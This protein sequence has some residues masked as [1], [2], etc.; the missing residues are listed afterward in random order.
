MQTFEGRNNENDFEKLPTAI[1]CQMILATDEGPGDRVDERASTVAECIDRSKVKSDD[2][3][4]LGDGSS[5]VEHIQL[6]QTNYVDFKNVM[7]KSSHVGS[8]SADR[9][10]SDVRESFS[11]CN[12]IEEHIAESLPAP[13]DDKVFITKHVVPAERDEMSCTSTDIHVDTRPYPIHV[14]ERAVSVP[15]NS[16]SNAVDD[17]SLLR[18]S[19]IEL[20]EEGEMYPQ[21]QVV[22]RQKTGQDAAK[23][24]KADLSS[25]M[26]LSAIASNA[27]QQKHPSSSGHLQSRKTTP[28]PPPPMPFHAPSPPAARQASAG[29]PPHR[30]PAKRSASKRIEVPA[31]T[32]PPNCEV[33]AKR[34]RQT[35]CAEHGA[36]CGGMPGDACAA[37]FVAPFP[38]VAAPP[39][40]LRAPVAV[41]KRDA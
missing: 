24:C 28:P 20:H 9:S 3:P 13:T 30:S 37:G 12:Q 38:V 5:S 7:V 27:P 19:A 21:T 6:M 18:D 4:L 8:L 25:T 23:V 35:P 17:S 31:E 15:D 22:E 26:N 36:S 41:R 34:A 16:A 14:E 33:P 32:H 29:D 40:L 2:P 11:V 10:R 1:P 39:S